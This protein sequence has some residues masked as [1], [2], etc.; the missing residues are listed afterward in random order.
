MCLPARR[1]LTGCE[2]VRGLPQ[3]P[4]SGERFVLREGGGGG[5][6]RFIDGSN[7]AAAAGPQDLV[8]LCV[9]A[10]GLEGLRPAVLPL[11]RPPQPP[12]AGGGRVISDCHFRKAATV[13]D[14]KPDIK[15]SSCAAK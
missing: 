12:G 5:A 14:R 6:V 15:R 8:L 13:H 4:D 7:A 3:L 10:D 2:R 11:L 1:W 9:P